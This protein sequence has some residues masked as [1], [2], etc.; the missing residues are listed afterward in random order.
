M[1]D[2]TR[3]TAALWA[4][5][6][7]LV[8][9]AAVWAYYRRRTVA[10]AERY[11]TFWPRFWAQSVDA[12]V[13]CPLTL[14]AAIVSSTA[15]SNEVTVIIAGVQNVAWFGY[16]AILHGRFGQTVGKIVTKV[17]VVDAK[18]EEPITWRQ[19]FRRESIP[20]AMALASV[21][22]LLVVPPADLEAQDPTAYALTPSSAAE[23]L[24]YAL[25]VL[26]YAAEV[27]TMLTNAKRRALH[28]FVGGTVAMRTNTRS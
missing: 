20:L 1:L 5:G 16:T 17:R 23:W 6:V 21:A 3:V 24:L 26:W 8:I 13:L 9:A 14:A 18:T 11:V 2:A 27:I 7:E 10:R 28:D 12:L 25:P 4:L 22:W 19:A 15:A